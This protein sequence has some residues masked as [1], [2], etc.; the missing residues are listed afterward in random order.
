MV[1]EGEKVVKLIILFKDGTKKEVSSLP[2]E[3]TVGRE[4]PA[5]IILPSKIVSR[6]HAI[7]SIK[8]NQV[9]ITDVSANGVH[10]D[11]K[12]IEPKVAVTVPVNIPVTIGEYSLV[13]KQADEKPAFNKKS[14]VIE[15]Q[16][17]H[18]TP[19]ENR[20]SQVLTKEQAQALSGIRDEIHKRLLDNLDLRWIDFTKKQ[21][22]ELK[23]LVNRQL[24]TIISSM[25]AGIP[26]WV[27]RDSLKKE[28]LDEV[29]GL[30]PLED[31]LRDETVSEI[32][33]IS[34]DLIYVER[35]GKI[36]ETTKRFSSNEALMAIIERIVSPIGKRIDESSPLVDARLKDGSR[37]N[38]I[39]PPL[40]L[41]GPCLTIRKFGSKRIT[42]ENLIGFGALTKEMAIF[43]ECC[44][45]GK[46]NIIIS[47]GTGSGKTTLLNVLSSFI[48]NDDRIVTI[49]DAAE[50]N[51]PQKHVVSLES[52]P[53]NVEGKGEISI[54]DLVKNS[55]RMRP[56]RII[57]GECR[58]GEALDMLQA[59]N[60]GHAGSMTTGHANSPD[61]ILRRL[62]T[63]VLMSG[64]ELPIR[65][66][67][68]QIASAIDVIVQQSRLS[69]GSRKVTSI[70]EIIGLDDDYNILTEEIFTFDKKG[71]DKSGKV[72]GNHTSTGYLPSFLPEL[73]ALGIHVPEDLFKV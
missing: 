16:P 17:Q 42:V 37:V 11:G 54:R 73:K 61:D 62:E 19:A 20:A 36:V 39:I 72:V 25:S 53:A 10:I 59:M 58:G 1:S 48:P 66:I 12:R 14:A 43:L 34:K 8:N 67:R 57:V 68:D 21:D 7:F 22:E 18:S 9:T 15:K 56:D 44:V 64:M 23:A 51:L 55:L 65:A 30:G 71:I 28:M 13:F 52:K 69:D 31:F 46:K 63:M 60:T 4:A 38:A 35:S 41:K 50:L 29:V 6:K 3:F 70:T 40:A 32:M 24:D 5:N 33:V 47:G 49:E 27:D 45:K 26:K 2:P